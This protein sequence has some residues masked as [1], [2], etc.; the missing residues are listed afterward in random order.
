MNGSHDEPSASEALH[1]DRELGELDV[2][3]SVF[4]EV[5]ELCKMQIGKVV[6]NSRLTESEKKELSRLAR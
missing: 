4:N 2:A 1:I 6:L 3:S 5:G